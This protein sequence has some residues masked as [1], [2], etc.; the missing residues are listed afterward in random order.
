MMDWPIGGPIPDLRQVTIA[1][2]IA[3]CQSP[4][5]SD[6]KETTLVKLTGCKANTHLK[7]QTLVGPEVGVTGNIH[8][9]IL[10]HLMSMCWICRGDRGKPGVARSPL[11][12][13]RA[14]CCDGLS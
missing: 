4:Q 5:R 9:A 6:L 12:T 11:G 14:T 2:S 13:V 8:R 3:V 10:D 7:G 1:C